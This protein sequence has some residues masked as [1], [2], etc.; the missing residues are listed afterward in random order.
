MENRTHREIS[1]DIRDEDLNFK[2]VSISLTLVRLAG[3]LRF[4]LVLG[5][6][7]LNPAFETTD[8]VLLFLQAFG[9]PSQALWNCIIFCVFDKYVRNRLKNFVFRRVQSNEMDQDGI[10]IIEYSIA[11]DQGD[12]GAESE[13]TTPII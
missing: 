7:H 10:A 6:A 2:Y 11:I 9:D 1:P 3:T 13:D 12:N 8:V 5:D 4:L